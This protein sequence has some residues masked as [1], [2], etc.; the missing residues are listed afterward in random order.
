MLLN[1]I[2]KSKKRKEHHGN[3]GTGSIRRYEKDYIFYFCG[4]EISRPAGGNKAKGEE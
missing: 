4:Y 3:K 2:S 1:G